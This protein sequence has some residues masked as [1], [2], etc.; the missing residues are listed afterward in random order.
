[1]V[2]CSGNWYLFR[3]R[4]IASPAKGKVLPVVIFSISK[5]SHIQRI[6]RSAL[7]NVSR[8]FPTFSNDIQ[9]SPVTFYR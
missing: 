1:M 5:N 7:G 6:S 9:F 4:R 2:N 8:A 3:S